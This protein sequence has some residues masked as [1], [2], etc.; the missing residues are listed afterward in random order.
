MGMVPTRSTCCVI[1]L[2][3][4][5]FVATVV[6]GQDQQTENMKAGIS[7]LE[8][9]DRRLAFSQFIELFQ[10]VNPHPDSQVQGFIDRA[11]AGESDS[12]ALIAY[13]IW[14][15]EA[16][17]RENRVAAK[18]ALMRALSEGSAQAPYF[19]AQTFLQGSGS[20]DAEKIDNLI[21]GLQWLGV[22]AGLGEKQSHTEAMR[23]IELNAKD[24]RQVRS[25]LIKFYNQGLDGAQKYKKIPVN[26]SAASTEPDWVLGGGKND[27]TYRVYIRNDVK[28]T[29]KD[30]VEA[31]EVWDYKDRQ[32][33]AALKIEYLSRLWLESFNCKEQTS[34]VLT[35]SF[36]SERM[37]K[38]T[39]LHSMTRAP[40]KVKY[41]RPAPGSPGEYMLKKV[42]AWAKERK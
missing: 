42:C 19:I 11:R 20:T 4:L 15:G 5:C 28:K 30:L 38:G 8:P 21:A 24:S 9:K 33:D 39:P 41:L 1:V 29:S 25:D 26:A 40:D 18:I 36:F 3:W 22:S 14:K 17:F 34:A 12:F 10:I 31:W 2:T 16:G 23:V 6:H 35:L 32:S 27:E 13:M 7:S 37:A